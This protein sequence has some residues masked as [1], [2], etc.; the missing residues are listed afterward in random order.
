MAP[1]RAG[2]YCRTFAH[3]SD[4]FVRTSWEYL[5]FTPSHST[6]K[7]VFV[8]DRA[9]ETCSGVFLITLDSVVAGHDAQFW[10]PR[11]GSTLVEFRQTGRYESTAI[12]QTRRK[13]SARSTRAN[14]LRALVPRVL[15]GSDFADRAS[16]FQSARH[17][18]ARAGFA[19]RSRLNRP[20]PR[21]RRVRAESRFLT[22]LQPPGR[23]RVSSRDEGKGRAAV[24][25]RD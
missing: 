14:P 1:L 16:P 10:D 3:I 4:R 9:L 15:V 13:P 17:R 21:I 25:G 5:L 8:H 18:I 7:T 20:P 22:A 6:F 23:E 11:P 12:P 24:L 19:P 2:K